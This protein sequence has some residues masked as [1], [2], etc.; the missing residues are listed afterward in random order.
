[1]KAFLLAAGLGTRLKP[2]TDKHPKAL[3]PIAGKTLLERNITFL[4]KFGISDIV[5]NIHHHGK[6]IIDFLRQNDNFNCNISISDESEQLLETGGG[7]L[8]ARK[9]LEN[10]DVFLMMNSDILTNIN[11]HKLIEFH[12]KEQP[13]AT[14]A[15]AERKTSRT[16]HFDTS[17]RL[18]GWKNHVTDESIGNTSHK[19]YGFLG[20]QVLSGKIFNCIEQTGKF[21][22]ISSYLTLMNQH[23]ILGFPTEE[24][25]MDVGKP[26]AI[27]KAEIWLKKHNLES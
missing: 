26:E 25:W 24:F 8:F 27:P 1:M 16:L 19:A 22:I 20:I 11:L 4:K 13:L 2:F 18:V 6:Q 5:I 3:L 10:E 15:I 12:K 7:L 23:P 14:L 9:Y 17:H 21:S